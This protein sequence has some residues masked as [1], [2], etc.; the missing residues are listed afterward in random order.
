M[1]RLSILKDLVTSLEIDFS[2]AR[3]HELHADLWDQVALNLEKIMVVCLELARFE[4]RKEEHN[5]ITDRGSR[6]IGKQ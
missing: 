2:R 6:R 1:E 5:P 4:V 3:K